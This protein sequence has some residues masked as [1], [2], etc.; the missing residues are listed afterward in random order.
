MT[1]AQ[2]ALKLAAAGRQVVL[3]SRS[4]LRVARYDTEPGWLGP[5]YMRAFRELED[6]GDRRRTI[7]EARRTGTVNEDVA[8][9]LRAAE[10]RGEVEL[11]QGEVLG[12]ARDGRCVLATLRPGGGPASEEG[13]TPVVRRFARV[14]LGTGLGTRRPG[15]RWLDELCGAEGLPTA[16]CGFPI[17]GAGLDWA[18]G[19]YA[20]GA[21]GELELGP[22]ARNLAGARRAGDRIVKH[23][24]APTAA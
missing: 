14:F 1:G 24:A 20:T 16:P 12:A 7:A 18:P 13:S 22:V 2:A 15:G 11:V 5:R 3:I 19:L 6:Y 17:V 21:L 23:A 4:P 9:A 8:S 10:R